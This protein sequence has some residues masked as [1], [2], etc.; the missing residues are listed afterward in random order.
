[1]KNGKLV[2]IKTDYALPKRTIGYVCRK[3]TSNYHMLKE[4]ID[5]LNKSIEKTVL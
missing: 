1:L 4:L 3:N 2:E 5:E